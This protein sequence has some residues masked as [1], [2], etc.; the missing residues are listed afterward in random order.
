[1]ESI[2]FNDNL[3]F[4]DDANKFII[5]IM[6]THTSPVG[7]AEEVLVEL[8]NKKFKYIVLNFSKKP[9]CN[10]VQVLSQYFGVDVC[11]L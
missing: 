2:S 3:K 1:L 11:N 4:R 10:L 5:H 8:R 6:K 9:D 7:I